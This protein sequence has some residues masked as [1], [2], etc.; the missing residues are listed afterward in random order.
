[1]RPSTEWGEFSTRHIKEASVYSH[2]YFTISVLLK[3]LE[4]FAMARK[5]GSNVLSSGSETNVFLSADCK[6]RLEGMTLY[7]GREAAER[8]SDVL[9]YVDEIPALDTTRMTPVQECLFLRN[10]IRC[11]RLPCLLS[12]TESTLLD[13]MALVKGSRCAGF[14][15][16]A[17][18]LT[19]FPTTQIDQQRVE[20]GRFGAYEQH[21]LC[22][23]RPLFV[24]WFAGCFRKQSVAATVAAA[25]QGDGTLLHMTPDTLTKMKRKICRAKAN[26][27]ERDAQLSW[28]HASAML[29]FADS[30]AGHGEVTATV[31]ARDAAH[32]VG[33]RKQRVGDL[34][35][36][37]MKH[38]NAIRNHFALLYIP[39]EL[40]DSTTGMAKLFVEGE[41]LHNSD[42][43]PFKALA[44]YPTC[45][46]DPLLY[47]ACLRG[48]LM[49]RGGNGA[50]GADLVEVP[51][52]YA[53]STFYEQTGV[54]NSQARSNDGKRLEGECM[55]AAV[56][57]AHRYS[58]FTGTPFLRWLALMVAELSQHE[59]FHVTPIEDVPEELVVALQAV[60]VPLLSPPNCPWGKESKESGINVAD[61]EWCKNC[62]MRDGLVP[63]RNIEAARGVHGEEENL[64]FTTMALEVK[65]TLDGFGGN[66]M[67]SVTKKVP[68]GC[69]AV[70]VSSHLA[71]WTRDTIGKFE[72]NVSVYR[73]TAQGSIECAS[74]HKWAPGKRL[75]IALDLNSL[76][77]GRYEAI[78]HST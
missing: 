23:S 65:D 29:I 41:T 76:H 17:W 31:V 73:M 72:E 78:P 6:I 54:G 36:N 59:L 71:E 40:I 16:Y 62:D 34:R 1:M 22:R 48:G 18:L 57:A 21:L 20:F 27:K 7:E 12:G 42:E 15:E 64:G 66:E 51:S 69:V 68:E 13:M 74:S 5:N 26:K 24:Q 49:W 70:L 11:L 37:V 43:S 8:Y 75:L 32:E 77:P 63:L 3:M 39:S 58:S 30:L 38:S 60:Q 25:P 56:L 4:L 28:L 10:I 47:L 55:A 46:Q 67:A 50:D 9:I 53:L 45:A 2:K 44:A 61:L 19:K 52:S 35:D 33:A 14:T